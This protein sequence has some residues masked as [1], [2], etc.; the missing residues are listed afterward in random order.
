MSVFLRDAS[1]ALKAALAANAIRYSANLYTI[2]LVDGLTVLRWTD[3]DR[4]LPFSGLEFGSR[5]ALLSKPAWKV[6]NTM[7]VPTLTLKVSS[8]NTA[9]LGGGALQL[10]IH[11]GLLDGAEFLMQRA[12]M[13][14]DASPDTLGVIG[15]FAG[16]IGAID[17]DGINASITVKG[18]TNDLDQ[19]IPRNLYQVPCLRAFCDTGCTLNRAD[20]TA[21]FTMG[22]TPTPVFIPW[23]TAPSNAAAY[24]GGTVVI[25]SGAASG[26]RRTIADASSAG[27]TLVYP[28]PQTVAPG[29][30]FTA[31]QGCDKTRNSGSNQSCS[32]RGNIVN[33]RGYPDVPPPASSY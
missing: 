3:F 7:E 6:V 17:L 32:A 12:M 30:A 1:P 11:D 15:L 2:T 10:Q 4:D 29:D 26:S 20:F 8:L 33:F 5:G 21:S 9:F 28:L 14:V 31:F 24:Q 25:T 16:K 27:L 19:Y 22:G 18:R 13:G 23:S